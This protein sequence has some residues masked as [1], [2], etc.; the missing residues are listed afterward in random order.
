[1]TTTHATAVNSYSV[2]YIHE[3]SGIDK[4]NP[5]DVTRSAI[6]TGSAM[7]SGSADHH[8]LRGHAVRGRCVERLD[9]RGATGYTTRSTAFGNHTQDRKVTATGSYDATG[10]QNG[11]DWVMQ[12]VAF[13]ADR[14][15]PETPPPRPSR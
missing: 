3:Y 1:M 10:T 15:A 13:R 9:H 14:P 11:A 4:V 12:L 8:Q 2:I 7:N 6:G 5:V